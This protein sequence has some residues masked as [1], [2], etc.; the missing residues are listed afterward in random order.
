MTWLFRLTGMGIGVV[1]VTS[2][3]AGPTRIEMPPV[4]AHVFCGQASQFEIV[5]PEGTERVTNA[6]YDLW[7]QAGAILAPLG[8]GTLRIQFESPGLQMAIM[9]LRLPS[10][11]SHQ[12]LL[13]RVFV[14][15]GGQRGERKILEGRLLADP[16]RLPEFIAALARR[17]LAVRRADPTPILDFLVPRAETTNS[18]PDEPAQKI[19][20]C[21]ST[22][23]PPEQ[24]GVDAGSLYVAFS[25]ER[26]G[27]LAMLMPLDAAWLLECPGH[28]KQALRDEPEV[29]TAFV[30]ALETAIDRIWPPSE[31]SPVP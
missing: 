4:L 19:F 10:N 23:R 7:A 28:W 21:E 18:T 25:G 31:I 15:S 24:D 30:S 27:T 8:R 16:R 12:E 26:R 22:D 29:D 5:L 2:V 13:L 11:P 1:L 14:E 17:G 3:Y 6:R 20:W 9:D